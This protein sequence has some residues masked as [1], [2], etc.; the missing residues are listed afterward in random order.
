MMRAARRDLRRVGDD[1][2]LRAFGQ[3]F[4]PPPDRIRRRA[5]DTP[6]DLVEDQRLPRLPARQTDFIIS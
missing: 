3:P 1:K 4:Q 5:T 6:V 2:D